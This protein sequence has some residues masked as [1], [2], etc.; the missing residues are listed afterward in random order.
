MD[1]FSVNYLS[2]IVATGKAYP[3]RRYDS[4]L[5]DFLKEKPVPPEWSQTETPE[6]WRRRAALEERATPSKRTRESLELELKANGI[7]PQ[8]V[9]SGAHRAKRIEIGICN[10]NSKGGIFLT[11]SLPALDSG[12]K[13]MPH[14]SSQGKLNKTQHQRDDSDN[15]H[16]ANC[17]AGMHDIFHCRACNDAQ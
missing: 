4:P 17:G 8:D 10:P 16:K 3:N 1:L 15:H 2:N 14:I 6:E 5:R 12:V 13:K 7:L 9:A 11:K